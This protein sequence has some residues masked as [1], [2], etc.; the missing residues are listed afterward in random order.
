MVISAENNN[1]IF[2]SVVIPAH[3]QERDMLRSC[4]T[5]LGKSSYPNFETI[6]VDDTGKADI[7]RMQEEFCFRLIRLEKT[8]NRAKARNIA[9]REAGGGILLFIDED[10]LIKKDTIEKVERAFLENPRLAAVFGSNDK[11]LSQGGFFSVWKH[12]FQYYIH[13]TAS[14]KAATFFTRCGAVKKSVFDKIGGFNE[15]DARLEDIEFGY[16]L[17]MEK[18][19]I[20]LLKE[21]QVTHLKK[22]SFFSLLKS[23]LLERAIPWAELMLKYKV[24]KNDLNLKD[25][26]I[27]SA[28]VSWMILSSL[29]LTIAKPWFYYIF[30]ALVFVFALLNIKFFIFSLKEKGFIFMLKSIIMLY[31]YYIYSAFGFVLGVLNYTNS[32]VLK[33]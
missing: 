8:V 15:A 5:A 31:I 27:A 20:L 7:L 4:L 10:T 22:Y 30:L 2:V 11:S 17:N 1:K 14:E 32:L 33:R 28:L 12:L 29:A 26:Y 9:S 16:K 24:F 6:V 13:Q 3:N 19:E 25:Q 18:Y 21:L 23:D